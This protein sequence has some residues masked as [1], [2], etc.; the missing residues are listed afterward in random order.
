MSPD[1]TPVPTAPMWTDAEH[2]EILRR[3][4]LRGLTID[5][6]MRQ[7]FAERPAAPADPPAAA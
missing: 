1:G 3:H 4:I 2:A 6:A 5:E 7:V